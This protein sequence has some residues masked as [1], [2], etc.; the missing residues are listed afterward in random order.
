MEKVRFSEKEKTA[1][2]NEIA[3]KFI[4]IWTEASLP[5]KSE[6]AVKLQIKRE[7]FEILSHIERETPNTVSESWKTE[8]SKKYKLNKMLDICSCNCFITSSKTEIDLKNCTC[9]IALKIPS[10]EL[11][12]YI[13]QKFERRFMVS[14]YRK[15]LFYEIKSVFLCLEIKI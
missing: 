1:I 10:E 3:I 4:K 9:D 7:I 6:K 11:E 8:I 15:T 12:F 2:T 5:V 13:D 14:S